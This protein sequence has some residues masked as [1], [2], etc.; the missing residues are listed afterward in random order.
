MPEYVNNKRLREVVN[1]YNSMNINDKGDW[2][3]NYLQ[4]LEHKRNSEK[5]DGQKFELGKDF[6]INKVKAIEALQAK[7]DAFTPEEKRAF[8]AEFEKVK[9]ELCEDFLLIINGRINS[10]KLRT[11]LRNPDDIN[12]IIQD[13]LI[14][15]FTY[16]NRYDPARGSSAFAFITQI[17]SNSIILSVNQIKDREKRMVSGLD[18][19]DNINTIDDPTDGVSGLARFMES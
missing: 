17:V 11:S 1:L 9:N 12:D 18:Y 5:I 19:F 14:C 15:A 6:I 2:C 10:Y 16:I 7:Y 8:D 13:A 3:A 4:R